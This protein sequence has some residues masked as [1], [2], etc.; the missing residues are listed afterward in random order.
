MKTQGLRSIF[1]VLL[2]C[3]LVVSVDS[4]SVTSSSSSPFPEPTTCDDKTGW[5]TWQ[6]LYTDPN[7]KGQIDVSYRT[8]TFVFDGGGNQHNF[9]FCN[10]FDVAATVEIRIVTEKSPKGA[11]LGRFTLKPK[12]QHQ[13][14]GHWTISKT[15][16][17]FKITEL[18]VGGAKIVATGKPQNPC[19]PGQTCLPTE[20]VIP[21]KS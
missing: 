19:P 21:V 7:D 18:T 16:K 17:E 8:G 1:I 3:F 12:S 6:T 11:Y 9:R 14:G 2:V 5:T 15:L 4:P 13:D 10:R 20:L